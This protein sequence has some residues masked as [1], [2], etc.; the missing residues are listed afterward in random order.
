MMPPNSNRPLGFAGGLPPA[1]RTT[2]ALC[3][4]LFVVSLVGSLTQRSFGLGVADLSFQVGALLNLEVWRLLTY[5]F[6]ESSPW[7]LLLSILFLWLFGGWFESRWGTRDFFRFFMIASVGAGVLAVPLCMLINLALPFRDL[8]LAEGPGAALDA[9]L[10]AMALTS[11]DSNVLFGF[12]LPMRARTVVLVVLGIQ[13]VIGIQTGSAV[14][15]I[16]LGG[17]AMGYLL[18]TGNWRPKRWLARW[19]SAR[20]R[21]PRRGLYVVPPRGRTLH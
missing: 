14:L 8:G 6:V 11:P 4:T 16:T 17:M 1:G 15:S 21:A 2:R 10:V 5:P 18:V 20:L 3:V 7:N 19:R 13:L 12:V 9:M